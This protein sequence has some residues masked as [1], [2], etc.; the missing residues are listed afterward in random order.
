MKNT[1]KID[2]SGEFIQSYPLPLQDG[3]LQHFLCFFRIYYP[4]ETVK[5]A[6]YIIGR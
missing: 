5:Q 3:V 1:R 6:E 2:Y 4:A